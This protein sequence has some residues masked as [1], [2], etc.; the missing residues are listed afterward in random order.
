MKFCFLRKCVYNKVLCNALKYWCN[1]FHN[2]NFPIG[3]SYYE[4]IPSDLDLNNK[5]MF[6]LALTWDITENNSWKLWVPEYNLSKI[7]W[8]IIVIIT[9]TFFIFEMIVSS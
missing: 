1:N 4:T 8:L 9:I 5:N 3:Q 7:N 6:L 2:K